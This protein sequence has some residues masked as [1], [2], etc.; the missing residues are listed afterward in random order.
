M[1]EEGQ[2]PRL[3]SLGEAARYCGL[4][5]SGFRNW[6]AKGRLPGPLPGTRRWDRR[7]IDKAL[8]VAS[9]IEHSNTSNSA[10][11]RWKLSKT[12]EGQA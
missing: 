4:S 9:H 12:R 8:D 7:A 5:V 3:L 10:Y 2:G 6:I 11:D 1:S